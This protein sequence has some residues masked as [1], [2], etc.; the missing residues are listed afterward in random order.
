VDYRWDEERAKQI[1]AQPG[2]ESGSADADLALLVYLSNLIGGDGALTQPGG[3]NSSVKRREV[4][5]AGRP[6]EVLRVKGSG[7]DL[8]TIGPGGFTGLRRDDLDHLRGRESMSDEEMMA[9]MRACMTNAAEPAPSVETPLHSVL[10]H[11][12]VVHTHDFATQVLTD[13]PRPAALVREA[14]GDEAAYVDY[15]RP[16]FPLARAVIELGPV[17]E[18]AR[19]L[20]LGQHGLIA[21][22]DSAKAC[23]DNLHLLI[24]RALRFIAD[25]RGTRPSISAEVKVASPPAERR[26]E[27][28]RAILPALRG[29]LSRERPVILHYDDSPEAL[30]F[31]GATRAGELAA[32]GMSTPEHILRCGREPLY[33][34][35]DLPA[36]APAQAT[37]AIGGALDRFAVRYRE[38]FERSGPKVEMLEPAPR[39]VLLPGLGLVTAM[40]DKA[41]AMVGN[42]CYRHVMRVADAA[43]A[44]GGFR[45]LDDADAIE[46]EYWPLE[47]AKLKQAERE[48]SR[49]VALITGAASGIGRA[50]AERFAAEGA[51]LVLTDIAGPALREAAQAIGRACKDAQRIVAVEADATRA[52]QTEAAFDQA[53]LAFGGVDIL[54]C[55]AGFIQAGP[56]DQM[57]EE[58]WDRHF[59]LNVK[60]YFL[61]ARAA[62]RTMKLGGR[63]GVIVFNASKGAFAPTADNAAYA[64]SKA[65]VAALARNLAIELGPAGIRVNYFNADFIDTPLMRGLIAQRAA[66]RGVTAEQQ[67]EEYRQRNAMHVGPIPAAAVAEAALFL[68]SPRARFTTGAA[69]PIDG[70]IKEAMP[71]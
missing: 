44:L 67:V 40:K 23:Y 58:T 5:F 9:F 11:R 62:V 43:E 25:R 50:I 35:A 29:R 59:D 60:G 17:A 7:T 18:K 3:G 46:F 15:V 14:L 27:L 22:G 63:G 49:Q 4:D 54:V 36:L 53:V 12:F 48:L 52:D 1:A 39:V 8:R 41:N 51:H 64:S 57:S 19:G 37:E 68:A 32:R 38:T 13:T 30:A 55:N 2:S 47:L 42:L 31:V 66:H 61:A 45:F 56:A 33:V 6:V 69:L 71:R 65:A 10:P 70:G 26:R 16:G 21:W 34:D 28:A 24:N 20:V